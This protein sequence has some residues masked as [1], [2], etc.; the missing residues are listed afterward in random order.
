MT[1][2]PTKRVYTTQ[3]SEVP[4]TDAEITNAAI[5]KLDTY[6]ADVYA[7]SDYDA[8]LRIGQRVTSLVADVRHA[9]NAE[10]A[11]RGGGG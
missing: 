10:R 4:M 2:R 11:A 7:S 6:A 8:L 3:V 1:E 5:Q 9:L